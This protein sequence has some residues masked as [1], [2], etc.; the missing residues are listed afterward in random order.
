MVYFRTE[1]PT[2]KFTICSISPCVI[3]KTVCVCLC[4]GRT[5]SVESVLTVYRET[6]TT[7]SLWGREAEMLLNMMAALKAKN[8]AAQSIKNDELERL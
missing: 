7:S 2:P 5:I 3:A 4:Q 8:D 6:I 1:P